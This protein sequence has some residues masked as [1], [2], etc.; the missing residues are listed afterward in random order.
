M[1]QRRPWPALIALLLAGCQAA[2]GGPYA[3]H[4]GERSRDAARR[5]A[6]S[7]RQSA[8]VVP[9]RWSFSTAAG[10]CVAIASG[11]LRAPTL[12]VRVD[13]SVRVS[14]SPGEG[15]SRLAFSGLGGSWSLRL[16]GKGRSASATMPLDD[17]AV[18]RLLVLLA[19]GRLRIEGG[20]RPASLILPGA[21]I[22]GRDWM[23]CV[24]A[25]VRGSS[26]PRARETGTPDSAAGEAE[27]GQ[28]ASADP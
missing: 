16:P 11:P 20:A 9:A 1:S 25:K 15:A 7:R 12:T 13:Q 14:A 21:G 3:L 18:G 10:E 17:S 26:A 22:S 27:P 4:A 8:E 23:G 2:P 6:A 19:G 5:L 28:A 24:S